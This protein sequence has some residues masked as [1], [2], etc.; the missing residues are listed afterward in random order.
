MKALK[1]IRAG[2]PDTERILAAEGLHGPE[3]VESGL[4][5][6]SPGERLWIIRGRR[7]N[8]SIHVY[9]SSTVRL[10]IREQTDMGVPRTS[11]LTQ[12]ATNQG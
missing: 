3:S 8:I 4:A 9:K 7:K 12:T 11:F 10:R 5:G 2:I 1:F 6:D